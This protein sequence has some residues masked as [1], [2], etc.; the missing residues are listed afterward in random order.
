MN[1]EQA[2]QEMINGQR[3]RLS[4]WLGYWYMPDGKFIK[5][6]T[7]DGDILEKPNVSTYQN[8]TDWEL[9]TETGWSFDMALR[10]MKNGKQLTRPCYPEGASMCII[11][12]RIHASI[13]IAGAVDTLLN[14][15]LANDWQIVN[16]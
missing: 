3:V 16:V 15:I 6:F 7:R 10:F 13:H 14:G 1:F 11:N 12:N 8:R 2:V 5:V 4:D 9:V